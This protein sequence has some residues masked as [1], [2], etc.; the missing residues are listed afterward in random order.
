MVFIPFLF[1]SYVFIRIIKRNGFDVS[2]CMMLIYIVTSFA[3]ILLSFTDYD[4]GYDNYSKI[5]I[6]FVPTFVFCT[7]IG[8]CIY[9][10][11]RYNSNKP[12]K[13]LLLR[14]LTLFNWI[15][16]LYIAVFF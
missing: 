5:E 14:S 1:F 4:F 3:S 11:F 12:R 10:F 7:F 6:T 16:Y 15:S 8:L 2:A 9:P 13:V